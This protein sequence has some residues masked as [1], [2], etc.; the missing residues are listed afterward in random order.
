[1]LRSES[2]I[3]EKYDKPDT[4]SRPEGVD[5][6]I[7]TVDNEDLPSAYMVRDSYAMQLIPQIGEHFSQL[8]AEEMWNYEIDYKVLRELKPDYVIYVI[9][10]RNIGPIFMK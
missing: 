6:I 3:N 4:I 9:A 5:D 10:E 1:M 2:Q 7:F 8:H